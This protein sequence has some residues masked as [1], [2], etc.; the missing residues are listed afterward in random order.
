MS[1]LE[2]KSELEGIGEEL[3]QAR[4]ARPRQGAL[5]AEAPR[6]VTTGGKIGDEA[7]PAPRNPPLGVDLDTGEPVEMFSTGSGVTFTRRLEPLQPASGRVALIDALAFSVVPPDGQSMRWVLAEMAR[8]LPIEDIE[9]RRGCF[10]FKFSKRFGKGA[11]L[12]AWGGRSQRDRVYFSIQGKGCGLVTDW[13]ALAAWL[14]AHR[15]VIKRVDVAY[16]DFAGETV[17]IAWALGQYESGGFNAG[18]RAPQH[19]VFGDWLAGEASSKGRTLGIGSRESGKYCRIYEKGKQLGEPGSAWTR[20]EVEWRGQD[21][22]I[23]AD[24]V[25]RPGSY[26]AGAYPCLAGLHVEQSRI[27]TIANAASIDFDAAV[28]HGRQ[29]AGRLVNLML[30]VFA[31]D[32]SAVVERLRRDGVPARLEAYSYHLANRPE[33]LD[34]A[35][36]GGFASQAHSAG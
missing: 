14:D 27:K 11:G 34:P 2:G 3:A 35:T 17:S 29:H 33:L 12:V 26:L 25:T 15:A 6:V 13:P 31:G 9:D 1:T 10:G 20:I 18:G 28:E 7:S 24:V 22:L 21:R 23:P 32:V 8:F 30:H 19:H 16:D 5:D 4:G 36:P